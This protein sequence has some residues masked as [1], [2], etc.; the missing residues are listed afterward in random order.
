MGARSQFGALTKV[1]DERYGMLKS[2]ANFYYA[3]GKDREAA[4]TFHGLIEERPLSP[5]APGF[6]GKIVDCVLRA[7]DK[8]K[9]VGQ[10]RKLVDILVKVEGSGVIKEEKDKRQLVE[11]RELAERT[12]S[13]L[14]VNWHK[15]GQKTRD[16]ETFKYSNEIYKDYLSLF[17]DSPKAYDLRFFWAEL[18]NDY[19]Q[20]YD[21]AAPE[22]DNVVRQDID[23]VE[24]KSKD[25]DGK[26]QKPGKYLTDA[27]Y[28]A[29]LAWDAV[30]KN[31]TESGKIKVE[32]PKD[33]GKAKIAAPVTDL[34]AAS[35]RYVKYVPKGEKRV[36]V[37]YKVAQI[38]YQYNHL[39]EA[40]A[41]F[42]EIAENYPTYEFEG[43]IRAAEVSANLVLDSFN[44]K[45][46]FESVNAWATKFYN[47][48]KLARGKFK[49]ELA[50]VL[51]KSAFKLVNKLE[52]R[53]EYAKA[54]Q[55]YLTFVESYPKSAIAEEALNNASI[56]FFKAKM[57]DRSVEVRQDLIRRYP[58]SKYV[59][60]A[61][62]DN[63]EAL[64]TVGDFEAAADNYELYVK[65]FEKAQ[66]A[67]AKSKRGKSK[68]AKAAAPSDSPQKWEEQ[69][70][71]DSLINA[72]VLREGLGQYRA[73]QRAREHYLEL[74]PRAK[75]AEE[76]FLSIGELHEKQGA[77]ARA[78]KHYE[79]YERDYG[80]VH[81][82]LLTAERRIVRIYEEKL[83]RSRDAKRVLE[84]VSAH[85]DKKMG[86][87]AR[88]KLEGEALEVAGL[89]SLQENE[90]VWTNYQRLR[91]RW[92][93]G[94]QLVNTFKEGMQEKI[95]SREMVKRAYTKTVAIGAPGPAICA[96]TRIGDAS[97]HLYEAL[98]DAPLPPVFRRR[99]SSR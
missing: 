94:N 23:K 71:Q 69:K 67:P 41:R 98:V 27:A 15:E 99:C 3:D 20:Q 65:S 9:T 16:E 45:E 47:N 5:E 25:K 57:L 21:R 83:N 33:G 77:W 13:N 43:G 86:R 31:Q 10:T 55:A 37:L 80:K 89:A 76:V 72:G 2:L 93:R 11:A 60:D 96:L 79:Q 35:E 95:R 44:I 38:Y 91:M 52:S 50:D 85:F 75:D 26:P 78:L 64:A 92:G 29:I 82:K 42:S 81:Q 51:E 63:A 61:I 88:A 97:A 34:L 54:A 24:G 74:W 56:D 17:G 46:D 39:D 12:L 49:A 1:D 28:N 70:A 19:L 4:I 18:L 66:G 22:Y 8:K 14:A 7:G 58:R 62:Y 59:P 87:T 53:K 40:I 68:K 32:I 90:E 6:Q 48:P 73:A 30:V 84:R 36:E